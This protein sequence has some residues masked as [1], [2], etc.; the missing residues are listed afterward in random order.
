MMIGEGYS[1]TARQYRV[2]MQKKVARL[3]REGRG[4]PDIVGDEAAL[5]AIDRLLEERGAS[6]DMRKEQRA[7]L[8]YFKRDTEG[9]GAPRPQRRLLK[10]AWRRC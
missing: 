6:S 3:I 1:R 2:T 4:G 8:L 9:L 5:C 10:T 7:R